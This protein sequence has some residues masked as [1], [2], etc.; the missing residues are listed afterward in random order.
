MCDAFKVV[1]ALLQISYHHVYVAQDDILHWMR[2]GDN[3]R[4][5]TFDWDEHRYVPLI[6]DID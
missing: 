5:Y 4:E 3:D 1:R 6:K 2:E